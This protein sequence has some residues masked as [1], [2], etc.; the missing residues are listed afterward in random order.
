MF[1]YLKEKLDTNGI[2]ALQETHSTPSIEEEWKKQWD[3]KLLFSHGSSSSKGCMIGF[4]KNL[5]VNI[6]KTT[7]DKNGRILI[8]DITLESKKYTIINLYNANNEQ[9]QINTLNSLKDNIIK[10]NLDEDRFPIL[11]GDLNFVFEL[12]LDA[13][14]GKPNLKKDSIASFIKI[15]EMLD[16]SDIFRIRYPTI[17]R[18]TFRQ[19]SKSKE[20]IHRRLDY[21]FIPDCLQEFAQN[22]EIL[23]SFLSDHSPVMLSLGKSKENKRG[24]GIW[25][26]NNVL[27]QDNSFKE[28][29]T[30]IIHNT[31]N[32]LINSQMTPHI[33]WEI[34]K[35]E[36]RKFCIKFSKNRAK[37]KKDEKKSHENTIQSFET[38]PVSNSISN[39]EYTYS[40]SWLEDWFQEQLNGTI[41][42]SK[43][44]W[45]EKG[46]KSSKYFLNLEKQNS[47]KNTIRKLFIPENG[48]NL[49]SENETDILNHAKYFYQNLYS[50]K[51]TKNLHDISKFLKNKDIPSI[52]EEQRVFCEKEI[53]LSELTDSLESMKSGKTPGNDG[54][55]VEFYKQFWEKIQGL[56]FN[57]FIYSKEVGELS[58]SQKQAIIKLLEKREKD[59]RYIENWRPI[60]LLNVDTKIIS[61]AIANKLKTVLPSIISHDQTA[62][63]QGRFIGESTR[64]ISDILDVTET[65]NIGGYMLTADIEK[66]FDSM[67]HIFLLEVLKKIGFG[68]YFISW[69]Q[70]LLKNN[71]S[72]VLNGGV[73]SKYF[74]LQRGARQGDPIAAYLFVIVLEV[75][76]I[77]IRSDKEVKGIDIFDHTFLLSAYA[78]DTT[79]FVK[80]IQSIRRI[81]EIFDYFSIFSGF[82]LNKSKCEVSGIGVMNGVQT[83][84]CNVKNVNLKTDSIKILGVHF[85][86]N[87]T[88]YESKNF[89][90]VICKIENM[91]KAWKMRSLTISGKIVIFKTLAISK[92]VYISHM[93]SV[94]DCII[95]QLEKIH[96]DFIW[97]NKK[98]KIKHSTLIND[99]AEGGLRDVDI[100]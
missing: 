54:L 27:L 97:S 31:S 24:R 51:V 69:I 78:D 3:G 37:A 43:S 17:K 85:S 56:F 82:K 88:I 44:V 55:T 10:H 84:L 67:D 52:S 79:F 14:G 33:Q 12:N 59:K 66:A 77:M 9:D 47:V 36:I 80:D 50:R 75:F 28:G 57:S 26:F 20:K 62:Y 38:D 4:T 22:I 35:Y 7:C 92:I 87:K 49:E 65:F 72:C 64:L 25:K 76:F 21:I 53:T 1:S 11:L 13:L 39:E 93:S 48:C 60:S 96:K 42:R 61:K 19:N 90:S 15:K 34:L 32:E 41:L 2:F 63:V 8:S 45:Y 95:S 6:E 18:F 98:A 71:E 40:K 100:K 81:F 89:V 16:I 46:E 86:Y 29:V 91:L 58:S 74:S 30:E 68:S 23:P 99:Y 83:A 73:T 70:I 94:P 5:D